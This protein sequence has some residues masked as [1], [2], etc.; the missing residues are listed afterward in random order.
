MRGPSVEQIQ[1]LIYP[2]L[3]NDQARIIPNFIHISYRDQC[4]QETIF[5]LLCSPSLQAVWTKDIQLHIYDTNLY[6]KYDDK[7][8]WI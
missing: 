2:I 8:F 4:R 6:V 7:K 3:L 5:V 1:T